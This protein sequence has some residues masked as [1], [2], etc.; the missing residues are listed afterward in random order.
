[1]SGVKTVKEVLV[2]MRKNVLSPEEKTL[3]KSLKIIKDDETVD[4]TLTD[5]LKAVEFTS[6][7]YLVHLK[8]EGTLEFTAPVTVTTTVVAK[9]KSEDA[10]T[11]GAVKTAEAAVESVEDVTFS[12]EEMK[13]MIQVKSLTIDSSKIKEVLEAYVKDLPKTAETYK[14]GDISI[15]W[16]AGVED[17]ISSLLSAG[18]KILDAIMYMAYKTSKDHNFIFVTK[19]LSPKKV[20][21]IE[22]AKRMD[23]GKKALL[24]SFC[25][26]Y[27]QGSLPS[28]TTDEKNLSKFIKETLFK[29][30]KDL[31]SNKLVEMLS[32]ADPGLFP[33]GIFLEID[34]KF[35]PTEVASRCKMS[36]AGNRA[37]RY[38]TLSMKFE[39]NTIEK[40]TSADTDAIIKYSAELAKLNK[41][42]QMVDTLSALASDFEAQKLMN[43]SNPKRTVRKNLTLQLTCAIITSLS[44]KGRA[45]LRKAINEGKIEAFKRDTNF[46]G[47]MNQ[48][49]EPEHRVLF[50]SEADFSELS[51]D[52]IKTAWGKS[53]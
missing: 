37:V 31:T 24:A 26:V 28:K 20:N 9:G 49:N 45:D 29:G 30:T 16:Y 42:Q 4:T 52:A 5:A 44:A 33:A 41:A 6:P 34:L 38:A 12:A 22:I 7:T 39:R 47:T 40:P 36:V 50:D 53:G 23:E 18:T 43:P 8:P 3:M 17:S 2:L 13:K 21:S 14:A 32:T 48:I 1:M 51:V 15:F 27:N 11:S 10:G 19:E 25:M 35:L 46:Y